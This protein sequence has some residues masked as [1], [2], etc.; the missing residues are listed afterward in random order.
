MAS[1]PVEVDSGSNTAPGTTQAT[2]TKT[3]STDSAQYI[4]VA[5]SGSLALSTPTINGSG[6]G[7]TWNLI[8]AGFEFDNT[9]TTRH[10]AI[11]ESLAAA[12]SSG[13][14]T[15]DFTG[16]NTPNSCSWIHVELPNTDTTTP[17]VQSIEHTTVGSIASLT[18]AY[19]GAFANAANISLGFCAQERQEDIVPTTA[20]E[21][22]E[23]QVAS[24][25]V[26]LECAYEVGDVDVAWTWLT[27][28][29][30]GGMGIEVAIA[31]GGVTTRRYSLTTL[32]VG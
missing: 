29:R 14:S 22:Q 32:G 31:A 16:G 27:S 21:I 1:I 23:I 30:A 19:A 6:Q 12:P 7:L 15:I 24:S 28:G 5:Q 10:L 3:P 9:G 11:F 26:T 2:N 17:T 4:G 18:L 13:T 25:N 8:D 20:I